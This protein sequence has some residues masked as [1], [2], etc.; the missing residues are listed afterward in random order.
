MPISAPHFGQHGVVVRVVTG[1]DTVMV[2]VV[3]MALL[4]LDASTAVW[5]GNVVVRRP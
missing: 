2:A 5:A 3:D 4:A 1:V